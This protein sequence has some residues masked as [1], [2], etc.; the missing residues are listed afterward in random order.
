M[1]RDH[2]IDAEEKQRILEFHRQNPV[3]GYRSLTFMMLDRDIVAVSPTT[4][5]RVLRAAGVL[6]R[7]NPK[8]SAKSTGFV[9][10][11]APHEHWHVDIAYLNV[12]G[13]FYYLCAVL[14][15]CSRALVHHEIRPAMT[16]K[17]VELQRAREKHPSAKPRIITDNGPPFVARDF[18]EFLRV[19]GVMHVRTSPYYPQSNGKIERWNRTVKSEK[20]RL[21]PSATIEEA[22]TRVG[23][24]VEN[25]NSMHHHSAVDYVTPNDVLA[26]R[27]N[28]ICAERDRKLEHAREARATRRARARQEVVAA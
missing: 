14:D 8:P 17:D 18:K 11:L 19:V 21:H 5:Y 22:R 20:I 9:Q 3:E 27:A 1:P 26:G 25:Y 24:F 4:T 12:G 15:G 7:W 2:W 16:E 10:P 23:A 6:D 28:A 13:T